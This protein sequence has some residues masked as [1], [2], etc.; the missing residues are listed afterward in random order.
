[1][2]FYYSNSVPADATINYVK[3]GNKVPQS[4]GT[5]PL[6]VLPDTFP[7]DVDYKVYEDAAVKLLWEVGYA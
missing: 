1:V 7:D 4:Q 5:R 2:R 6:M 3:N